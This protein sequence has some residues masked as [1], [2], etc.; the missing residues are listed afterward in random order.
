M[1]AA[2]TLVDRFVDYII[3]PMIL[4]VFAT[5][6]FL[7]VWG[8]VQFIYKLDEGAQ[9]SGKQHM[10]WGI[11]GMLIMVSVYGIIGLI[12]ETFNLDIGN[13]DMSRMNNITAPANFGGQ[14]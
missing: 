12:D 5:G 4:I 9:S 2:S 10:L 14:Q 6:F 11:V 1:N 7:F 13:P 3:N 8:L